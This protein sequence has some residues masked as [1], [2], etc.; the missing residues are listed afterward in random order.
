MAIL[1]FSAMMCVLDIAGH[2]SKKAMFDTSDS[3]MKM[4][5]EDDRRSW[6]VV[7]G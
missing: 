6:Y 5:I 3:D 4:L 1:V 2:K 7:S